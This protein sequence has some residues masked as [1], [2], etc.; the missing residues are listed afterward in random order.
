[1][2]RIFT[3]A[4]IGV[5]MLLRLSVMA[6]S[7]LLLSNPGLNAESYNPAGFSD[8]GMISLQLLARQQ[9]IGFPDAPSLQRLGVSSFFENRPMGMKFN[10]VNQV[11]GKEITRQAKLS[12]AY[13]VHFTEGLQ[14]TMGVSAGI[15]S[16]MI[17]Y[18]ELVF[19]D[20]NEPLVKP[21]ESYL[22]PDFDF[23]LELQRDALTVGMAANHITTPARKATLFKIPAHNHLYL[24]YRI[25]LSD[26]ATLQPMLSLHKQGK[27]NVFQL[28][29]NLN[30]NNVFMAGLGYRQ[31]D[32]F[33]LHVGLN[34]NEM[35]GFMYSYDIGATRFSNYNSG[36]HEFVLLV[37]LQKKSAAFL[38]PRFID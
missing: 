20:G 12:Y 21:D 13:R 11:A 24:A 7:D 35:I 27:L 22:L 8:N 17:K 3:I 10:L 16:R 31:N 26:E 29:A 9:W 2:R 36:T 18:S 14:L 25:S 23:G 33:M 28:D 15:Y 6:Q 19:Y 37:R 1:M 5:F 34:V 38:S 32:A 4:L 30:F